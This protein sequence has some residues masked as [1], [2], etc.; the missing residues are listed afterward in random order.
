[1]TSLL[2]AVPPEL[3]ETVWPT[4]APM[5]EKALDLQ[6]DWLTI[7]QAR[8]LVFKNEATLFVILDEDKNIK[9]SLITQ[10]RNHFNYRTL[11]VMAFGGKRVANTEATEQLA[12]YARSNGCRYI[13]AMASKSTARLYKSK[14]GFDELAIAVRRKV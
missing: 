7:D 8:L 5:L 12:S 1:M 6:G 13:E 10:I 9:G 14:C 11:L 2:R 3:L 4:V